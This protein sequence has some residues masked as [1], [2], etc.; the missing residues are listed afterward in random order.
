VRTLLASVGATLLLLA[1]LAAPST[2]VPAARGCAPAASGVLVLSD[3]PSGY[4]QTQDAHATPIVTSEQSL[5]SRAN[6]RRNRIAACE[7]DFAEQ[8]GVPKVISRAYAYR[9]AASAHLALRLGNQSAG[10][11]GM[12]RVP[13]SLLIGDEAAL[14][15]SAESSRGACVVAWRSRRALKVV[16]IIGAAGQ[17]GPALCI[18]LSRRQQMHRT[19]AG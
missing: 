10:R 2:A 12:R 5:A 16:T 8:T 14:F 11:T 19:S 15:I 17:A 7:S 6:A 9:S 3:L 4:F 1:C 18:D 13:V